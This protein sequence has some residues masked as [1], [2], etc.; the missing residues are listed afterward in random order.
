[1]KKELKTAVGNNCEGKEICLKLALGRYRCKVNG[2][3]V[4]LGQSFYY[5]YCMVV[6]GCLIGKIHVVM[7]KIATLRLTLSYTQT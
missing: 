3:N 1:M 5:Y 2:S 7:M 4:V 6:S